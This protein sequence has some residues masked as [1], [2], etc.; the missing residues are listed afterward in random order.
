M[1]SNTFPIPRDAAKQLDGIVIEKKFT[2]DAPV[3]QGMRRVTRQSGSAN[4]ISLRPLSKRSAKHDKHAVKAL[5]AHGTK[6]KRAPD[7]AARN[8]GLLAR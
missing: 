8:A 6:Y 3:W 5:I 2:F 7:Y 1:F 4:Y